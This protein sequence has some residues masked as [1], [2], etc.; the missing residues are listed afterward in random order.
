MLEDF[1]SKNGTFR[2]GDRLTAPR[3]LADGD[4]IRIGSVLLTFH[5]RALNLGPMGLG[6]LR[7]E[8]AGT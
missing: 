4:A 6:Q 7:R 1:A 2:G 5:A 3:R 8:L